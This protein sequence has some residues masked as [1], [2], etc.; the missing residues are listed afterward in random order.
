M[1]RNDEHPQQPADDDRFLEATR[2]LLDEMTSEEV[3]QFEA[4]LA[5][6]QSLRERL[7]E[8]VLLVQASY[9]AYVPHTVSK[10]PVEVA[11][12]IDAAPGS[13]LR[14][15][16]LLSLAAG[17][18]LF[19][20]SGFAMVAWSG[21]GSHMAERTVDKEDMQLAAV[22]VERIEDNTD[23]LT[24]QWAELP[25]DEDEFIDQLL[26]STPENPPSWMLKALA[27]QQETD[28]EAPAL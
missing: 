2:Y 25:D 1:I 14:L 11:S 3:E 10:E 18:L 16:I 5:T 22:W 23:A 7:A 20:A 12:P 15:R 17:L 9:Q 26:V 8:A 27:A 4:D 13:G 6:D 28:S 21:G 19:L 24:E